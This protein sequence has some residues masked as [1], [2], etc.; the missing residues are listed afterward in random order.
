VTSPPDGTPGDPATLARLAGSL[1]ALTQQVADLRRQLDSARRRLDQVGV[2]QIGGRLDDL[3]GRFEELSQAV[4]DALDAA[5]PKGPAAPRW[6]NLDPADRARELTRL[7]SWVAKI[8]VP[9]YCRAG[10][11]TLATCWAN[12]PEA[13][14]ELGNLAVQWR[15]IY[16]RD[17]PNVGLALEFFDRW[18]P[19]VMRHLAD[20]TQQCTP[21]CTAETP[22][23]RP[24]PELH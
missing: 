9:H 5:S 24:H 7:Q 4:A 8:L 16:D 17:R 3:T 13:L 14:W 1:G 6:D 2:D 20:M 22:R 12:H 10:A 19:S 11:Y 18:L 23:H 15:R 21:R